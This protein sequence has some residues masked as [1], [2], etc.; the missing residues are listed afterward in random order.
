MNTR[1]A[2]IGFIFVT[3]LIDVIGWGIIIPVMP[4]LISD[5]ESVDTGNASSLN[6]WMLFAFSL[7]QFLFAPLV[8]IGLCVKICF[9]D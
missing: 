1:K 4:G 8:G 3:L 2:A 7:T 5:M 6:G 9:V